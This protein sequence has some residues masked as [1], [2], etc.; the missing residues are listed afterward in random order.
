[1]LCAKCEFEN[2]QDMKFCGSCGHSLLNACSKCAFENPAGFM[3]CGRC[4]STLTDDPDPAA[5]DR[6][7][8]PEAHMDAML[9]FVIALLEKQARIT[10]RS[11]QRAFAVD[12]E[13]LDRLGEELAKQQ[14]ADI[15][16]RQTLIRV[17]D[18]VPVVPQTGP[19]TV[20]KVPR[21]ASQTVADSE[22]TGSPHRPSQAERRQLTVM[23]CDLVGSTD[24]SG[25]LDPEDLREVVQTYQKTAATVIEKYDGHIAQYLGDGLLIYFGYPLAHEDDAQR[26]VYTGLEILD[27]IKQANSGLQNSFSVSLAVRIGI[28]TGPVVVGEI[29]GGGRREQ[30]AL[31]ETPNIAA[32]IEG[33]AQ[34]NTVA[35][36]PVTADLVHRSFILNNL[37]SHKLK[38]INE[39]MTLYSVERPGYSR[40]ENEGEI[41]DRFKGLVGRSEEI[42][43]LLRRWQQS[44]EGQGQVV[45]ISG[46]AGIGKSSL[47]NSIRRLVK[48]DSLPCI[49]IRCSRYH[50]NSA[51]FPVVNHLYRYLQIQHDNS[52]SENLNRL[53]TALQSCNMDLDEAVPLFAA[54][55]ALELPGTR[56]DSESSLP[57]SQQRQQ[58]L[59]A[60][61]SWILAESEHQPVLIL[62]EDL[63]WADPTTLELLGALLEQSPTATILN[64][65]ISRLDFEPPWPT[66]SYM[67]SLRLTRLERQQVESLVTRLSGGKQLPTEVMD[68][69]VNKTDGVP[70]FVEE[71]TKTIINSKVL[72][73]HDD[74][75]KLTGP[76]TAVAIPA[77]LNDSLM[78]RLD[79]LPTVREMAQLGS[80]VGRE[81]NYEIVRALANV[82]EPILQDGLS[83]LVDH[84]L[85]YQRGRP[86]Q[87]RYTF[88]HALV[89]DAAY[90]SLLRRTRQQYH[91]Q[92]AELFE[93]RFVHMIQSEPEVLAYHYTEANCGEKAVAY[94]LMAGQRAAHSSAHREAIAHLS[95]GLDMLQ[96]LPDSNEK[97]QQNMTLHVALGGSLIAVKGYAASEVE[98]VYTR[99]RE[100]C[101]QIG[102]RPQVF[103]V[104]RGLFLFYLVRGQMQTAHELAQQMLEQAAKQDEVSP[105]MLS[106]YLM[107]MALF[108]RADLVNGISH[109]Q[110]AIRIHNPETHQELAYVYGIDPGV[111][112]LG[113]EALLQWY[114]GY[115]DQ[116]LQL[117]REGVAL[118]ERVSHPF[119]QVFAH[120]W[121]AWIHQLRRESDGAAESANIAILL[122]REQG[123][124]LY[125]AWGTVAQGWAMDLNEP[126]DTGMIRMQG[127]MAAALGTGSE[128]FRPF[129]LGLL[130]EAHGRKGE[131]GRG[132]SV[133]AEACEVMERT[134]EFVYQAE[135]YRLTGEFQLHSQ[136]PG[137]EAAETNFNQAL[138]VARSHQARSLELRAATSLARLWHKQNRS[139]DALDLLSPVIDCFSE[140][141]DTVDFH[142][143][144]SLQEKLR[145]QAQTAG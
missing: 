105:T 90:Q 20:T 70:L 30:L 126:G 136:E 12:E 124:A 139:R 108:F 51:L 141:F 89:Q 5:P 110:E 106:H 107:G 96:Q 125:E 43:L 122:A 7:E 91:Q 85:L 129:F 13:S 61:I 34:T 118:A 103:Q 84:E 75:F 60:L 57:S 78:A 18:P 95:R 8:D 26:A 111:G 87:S 116:A 86:P 133:L 99:A 6:T 72:N 135:I 120:D 121:L 45:L 140:G 39:E 138:A 3:Y 88:K 2:P 52:A 143:A 93:S 134:G 48:Q 17:A 9:P 98:R 71:L 102:D 69:I 50:Q 79:R 65:L 66:R 109:I 58:T 37:G 56:Y 115:P 131:F 49:T 67:T 114:L 14:I 104:L 32:R 132:L 44:K 25:K 19:T 24:L 68:H 83:Q 123:F 38:G 130:A 144:R 55:L 27:A 145:T 4:G 47:V 82:D 100:L 40:P 63:H 112:S 113:F 42:S 31:G 92:V 73:E 128:V 46:E 142:D 54:L 10:R 15:D 76:L 35:I 119:S 81:F 62:W 21:A 29:G 77:T 64:V 33:L 117:A 94:W 101:Q 11:L 23:F 41:S 127:G 36:S 22:P 59:D 28:H 53:E 137:T 1:M 80:V 74:H 16:E 97:L